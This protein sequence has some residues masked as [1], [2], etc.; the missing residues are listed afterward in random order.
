M[1]FEFTLSL[2]FFIGITACLAILKLGHVADIS[3]Y[4]VIFPALIPIT[5]LTTVAILTAIV[6]IMLYFRNR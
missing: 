5:F 3:W 2:G 4:W 1:K 6:F